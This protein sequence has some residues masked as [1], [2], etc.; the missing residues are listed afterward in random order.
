MNDLL[1]YAYELLPFVIIPLPFY[2]AARL[3]IRRALKK[4]ELTQPPAHEA[5]LGF[6]SLYLLVT[7][8]LLLFP[9]VTVYP[10]GTMSLLKDGAENLYVPLDFIFNRI[11]DFMGGEGILA[12][13]GALIAPVLLFVPVGFCLS[14]L[15]EPLR[16][17]LYPFLIGLGISALFEVIQIFT[18]RG[19][20]LDCIFLNAVGALCGSLIVKL[21]SKLSPN[22]PDK[23][24]KKYYSKKKK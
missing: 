3:I 19:F 7:A 17:P 16:K 5:W 23:F 2:G 1:N 21:I 4:K 15:W 22:Y 8:V 11:G 24:T 12:V 20:C 13:I 18:Y 10:D 9:N 6:L 14:L